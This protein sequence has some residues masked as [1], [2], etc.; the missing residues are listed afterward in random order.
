MSTFFHYK[1]KRTKIEGVK[2]NFYR[3]FKEALR[4]FYSLIIFQCNPKSE[5][6]PQPGFEIFMI[7]IADQ[8]YLILHLAPLQSITCFA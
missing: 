3:F 2:F 4:H 7:P 8:L 6:I 5:P 1:T